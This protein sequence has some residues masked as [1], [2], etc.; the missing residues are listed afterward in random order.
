MVIWDPE[1][2]RTEQLIR[3]KQLQRA[4]SHIN[5]MMEYTAD[6]SDFKKD[7]RQH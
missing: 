1:Q 3:T 7:L 6:F 5:G 4:K 2:N